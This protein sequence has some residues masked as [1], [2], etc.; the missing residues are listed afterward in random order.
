MD[1][2]MPRLNGFEATRR[3][4]ETQPVPTVICSA[5]TDVKDAVAIF[6]ALEVGAIAL[7]EKPL[8]RGHGDFDAL[9]AQLLQTVKLMA[10]V[11]VVRRST[12]PARALPAA[13]A[14]ASRPR[15]RVKLIGIG[16]STGGPP[17]LQ[18]ILAG[19]PKDFPAPVLIVQHI[20]R[21]FLAGM[22]RWLDQTT[23][24]QVH[25][26]SAGTRPLPGHAYLAPDDFH[27]GIADGGT[28]TLTQE[29][30]ESL[31]RPAVSFLF[32][33]L[34][35][36]CGRNA[37]G[38]LLT[39]MGRD[40]AEGLKAMRDR[41]AITIAQ[42]RES[43]VIH[44]MPAAAIALGGASHVLAADRIADFLVALVHQGNHIGS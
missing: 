24:M 28:I 20:A 41:G 8:G 16:A 39:G 31:Q 38:V 18:T 2:H 15:A 21:G 34:A 7:I 40:G 42:D 43:S 27:M 35:Q 19:L 9:A 32:R 23:G 22:A 36:A 44:S 37:L 14:A 25:I 11:K 3:I 6:R 12:R 29:E 33:T 5:N 13:V 4:M 10:E 1:V 26:A 30:P 17:V